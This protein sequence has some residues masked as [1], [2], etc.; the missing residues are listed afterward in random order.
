MLKQ[1]LLSLLLWKLIIIFIYLVSL[2]YAMFAC[3]PRKLDFS[4]IHPASV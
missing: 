1:V 3:Q 4:V 2:L